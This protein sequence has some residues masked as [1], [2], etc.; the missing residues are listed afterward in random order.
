MRKSTTRLTALTALALGSSLLAA[1]S[2]DADNGSG[3][4]AITVQNCGEDLTLDQQVSEIYA[5]DGGIISIVVAAGARDELVAVTGMARDQDVLE[6]AYPD[7]RIDELTVVGDEY[8]QLENALAVDPELMFAGWNYGFSDAR[9][10]VPDQLIEHD[11]TPYILSESCLQEDGARGTMDPWDALSLDLLNIGE[12]T[13]HQDTAQ[14]VVD[15]I[16]TRRAELS[17]AP[18][19]EEEP[20]VFLFDSGTDAIFTSGSFGGPQAIFDTAGV[21]SATADIEDTWT[22]VS[23]ER[24]NSSD[25]D[26]IFFVD[27][28]GQS[29]EE[30]V[31]VLKANPAS[32]NLEAVQEERFVNLPYALWVSSPQNIDAAEWVRLAAEHYDLV[33]PSGIEPTLDITE[34]DSLPGNDWAR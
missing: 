1:C 3:E 13:G 18:Q 2:S 10:F 17:A 21:T 8:P 28:P 27:Y 33:P 24:L 25:P 34:L 19:A 11:I 20:T 22:E 32:A 12:L 31:A 7:Q 23:W 4:G 29:Y 16:E 14:A 6:L 30:K 5:Y 15:D 9:N 26:M